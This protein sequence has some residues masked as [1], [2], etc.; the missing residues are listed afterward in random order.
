MH[1]CQHIYTCTVSER[2][3]ERERERER[4][5][6]V[7]TDPDIKQPLQL[8]LEKFVHSLDGN[9]HLVGVV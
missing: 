3:R 7:I 5:K 4:E 6:A 1:T 9:V 2:A 8:H